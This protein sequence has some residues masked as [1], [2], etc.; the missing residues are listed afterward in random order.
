[1]VPGRLFGDQSFLDLG[2]RLDQ[3][4]RPLLHQL[5]QTEADLV[6]QRQGEAHQQGGQ[7]DREQ[8]PHPPPPRQQLRRPAVERHEVKAVQHQEGPHGQQQGPAVA[9]GDSGLDEHQPERDRR[10]GEEAGGQPGQKPVRQE[11]HQGDVDRRHDDDAAAQGALHG[12][13][14]A[15]QVQIGGDE[16]GQAV[17]AEDAAPFQKPPIDVVPPGDAVGPVEAGPEEGGDQ[18]PERRTEGVGVKPVAQQQPMR[19]EQQRH[20]GDRPHQRRLKARH[21]GLMPQLGK[22]GAQDRGQHQGKARLHAQVQRDRL[23]DVGRQRDRVL[24]LAR[25]HRRHRQ[26]PRRVQQQPAVVGD[27]MDVGARDQQRVYGEQPAVGNLGLGQ[28]QPHPAPE[29]AGALPERRRPGRQRTER[30]AA[31]PFHRDG[32]QRQGAAGIEQRVDD[33]GERHDLRRAG[34]DTAGERPCLRGSL[35]RMEKDQD[36]GNDS[37][38]ERNKPHA[39]HPPVPG[40]VAKEKSNTCAGQVARTKTSDFSNVSGL[41]L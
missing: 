26:T 14:V 2:V 34:R 32:V 24:D 22:R 5:A 27:Q 3:L 39:I 25:R 11:Q 10:D 21:L 28:V 29:G 16:Q 19:P 12:R 18:N 40:V 36:D 4:T 8:L 20:A 37:S 33:G 30:A 1:M 35:R 38:S 13:A 9:P 41:S 7:T 31:A 15:G 6:G 17:Q 23:A